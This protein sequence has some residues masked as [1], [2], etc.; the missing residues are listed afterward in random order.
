MAFTRIKFTIVCPCCGEKIDVK[1]EIE[2]FV[3]IEKTGGCTTHVRKM[4]DS[5]SPWKITDGEMI[6][7]DWPHAIPGQREAA[8]VNMPELHAIRL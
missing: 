3:D 5:Q 8:R 2:Y 6:K 7:D 4:E 1:Q